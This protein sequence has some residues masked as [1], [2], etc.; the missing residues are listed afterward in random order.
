MPCWAIRFSSRL[1]RRKATEPVATQQKQAVAYA[2]Y[3]AYW[4][5]SFQKGREAVA[6]VAV[7]DFA[8]AGLSHNGGIR[9]DD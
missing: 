8:P 3:C 6:S 1:P 9:Y 4:R 2:A 7:Y 5:A